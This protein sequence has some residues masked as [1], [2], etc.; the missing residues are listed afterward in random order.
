ALNA[1]QWVATREGLIVA[2]E[3]AHAF[4]VLKNKDLFTPGTRVVVNMS[5]RGDKDMVSVAQ[6]LD[7]N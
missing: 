3:T 5:G 6:M 1:L 7:L 4:A 2:L